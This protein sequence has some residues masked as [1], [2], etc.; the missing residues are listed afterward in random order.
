MSQGTSDSPA[1]DPSREPADLD[2]DTSHP[3][4]H[5]A[6]PAAGGW[7]ITD[8][9]FGVAERDGDRE[10]VVDPVYGRFTYAEIA[11]QV[12]RVAHGL[13]GHGFGP[14]DVV[15]LQLPYPRSPSRLQCKSP[16]GSNPSLPIRDRFR[17]ESD[18]FRQFPFRK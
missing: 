2:P 15:I 8:R 4:G 12:E 10:L 3:P 17:P 18:R 16:G 6:G 7:L 9:L 14:G 11:T 1:L 5:L 13:R